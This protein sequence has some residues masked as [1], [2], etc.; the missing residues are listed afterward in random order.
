VLSTPSNHRVH[1][2]RNPKYIDRNYGGTFI[3]WDRLFGTYKK[4]EE[5][6][7]YGITTPLQSWNPVWAN[8]SYWATMIGNARR[9]DRL[10]DKLRFFWKPPGWRPV[11]MGGFQPAPPV[12]RASYVKFAT[13]P[14]SRLQVAYVLVQFVAVLVG[15]VLLL[16]VEARLPMHWLFAGASLAVLSLVTFGALLE[17]RPWA[18]AG[19]AARLVA[20]VVMSIAWLGR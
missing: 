4:E 8:L 19:E 6:P 5:E 12:D 15:V 1:H 11:S 10:V 13:P 7:V 2:A 20:L 17:G 3:V 18:K 14:L 16:N 9:A